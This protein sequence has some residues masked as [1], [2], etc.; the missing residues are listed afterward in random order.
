MFCEGALPFFHIPVP[1][2]DAPPTHTE[3][4]GLFLLG[5]LFKA[6]ATLHPQQSNTLSVTAGRALAASGENAVVKAS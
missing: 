6:A 2:K 5:L 4:P 1:L 3:N